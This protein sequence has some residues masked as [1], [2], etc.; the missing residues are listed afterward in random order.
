MTMFLHWAGKMLF[1][2]FKPRQQLILENLA[3]RQ[4]LGVLSRS[5]KRPQL[6]SWDRV[7]W[8]WLS[9][10]WNHWSE[11]LLLVQPETVV[12]WHRQG[13]RLYWAWKRG[14]PRPGRPVLD[15]AVRDLIR[16]MSQ[17]NPLWGA[18]RIHGEL[19]KLGIDVSQATVSKY[20][21]RNRKPPSQTWR[22]FLNNHV[23]DL[24]SIDFFTL[25]TA[26]FRV[27]YGF[28]VLSHQRRCVVHFNV[29]ENPSAQWTAQQVI[30]AFLYE[31]APR[32]VLRDRDRIYAENFSAEL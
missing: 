10:F 18:P 22:T 2:I 4:Q 23:V 3:L 24:A 26:T 14:R 6:T 21:V 16:S 7:F 11:A 1:S 8:V 5:V 27:L 17:S 13:F 25:L 20:M 31:T 32:Y 28:L 29:T 12:W 19:L 15:P 30:E 9:R